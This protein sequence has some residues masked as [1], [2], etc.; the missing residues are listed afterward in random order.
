MEDRETAAAARRRERLSLNLHATEPLDEGETGT[1]L[2][3]LHHL[4]RLK[5]APHTRRPVY[6]CPLLQAM[7]FKGISERSGCQQPSRL[8]TE[9]GDAVVAL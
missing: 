8:Q 6:V 9:P 3:D 7:D 2:R 5:R 4:F 1:R